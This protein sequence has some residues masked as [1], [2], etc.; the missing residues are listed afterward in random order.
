MTNFSCNVQDKLIVSVFND[1]SCKVF[2]I[3]ALVAHQVL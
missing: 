3:E 1:G 2:D